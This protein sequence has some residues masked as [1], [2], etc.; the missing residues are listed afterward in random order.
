MTLTAT[1][2]SLSRH[3]KPLDHCAVV[4]S[5]LRANLEQIQLADRK[6]QTLLRLVLGLFMVAFVG[7]P[8]TVMSLQHFYG[9]G[10][11]ELVV[12]MGVVVLYLVCA[13][14]LLLSM[15]RIIAVIRPRLPGGRRLPPSTFFASTAQMSRDEFRRYMLSMDT[16][17]ALNDLLDQAYQTAQIAQTKYEH[18]GAAINWMLG[19]GVVGILFAE[20]LLVT[21]GILW[22]KEPQMPEP[23][24][25][26]APMMMHR[27]GA[28]D[29]QVV[30][31]DQGGGAFE[32]VR[33]PGSRARLASMHESTH[34]P[35][36][37]YVNDATDAPRSDRRVLRTWLV[38]PPV[39]S[40]PATVG[41]RRPV[42]PIGIRREHFRAGNILH[43]VCQF[44]YGA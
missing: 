39:G 35:G 34:R 1:T 38:T 4:E 19:G 6:A 30:V 20:V 12:F 27:P 24:P 18:L 2:P 10:G 28:G 21:T 5:R 31:E 22:Q 25:K 42:E 8:P 29:D 37:D 23:A 36:V 13:G 17:D 3:V 7:V 41:P 14:C 11:W 32:S 26:A 15:I 33:W 44:Y 9:E 16:D 43:R 40:R